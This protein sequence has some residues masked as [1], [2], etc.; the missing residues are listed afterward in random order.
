MCTRIAEINARKL[1]IRTALLAD[2]Q[3][4]NFDAI[5]TELANLEKEE[6][7]L[8]SKQEIANQI[9]V[10]KIEAT[11][12]KKPEERKM[13]INK[14]ETLE[15]RQAFMAHVLKGEAIPA[16]FRANQIT[17]TTDIGAV[18]PTNVLNKV[19][20]KVEATGMIL[21]LVTR[22]AFK[23]GL[24]IPKSGVKPVATWVAE[25]ATSDKQK[26]GTA[27][28]VFAYHKLRC[29]VAMSLEADTMA[30][31]AFEAAL[32]QNVSEAMVKAIEQA[33]ISG[34]GNGKPEGILNATPVELIDVTSI[35]YKTLVAAEAAIPS[36]YEA[37]A[38]WIMTKKTFMDF[39]GMVDSSKQP[40]ARINYGISGKPERTLLGRQVVLCNYIDSFATATAGKPV[41]FLFDFSN[42]VLNTNFELGMKRYEDIETEDQVTKA[43]MIVDGKVVDSNSLVV[44]KKKAS[45]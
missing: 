28:I 41:A 13:E 5:K 38:V 18:I 29:A 23:G 11:E 16:E 7:E 17:K 40:I 2:D 36:E 33:I 35:D 20:E 30:L 42:Y 32:I 43:V 1:E 25:G 14:L 19:I 21:S 22:T 34:D 10:G 15:Y 31:P 4:L 6:K 37:N 39:I 9:N 45:A 8:R 24:S 26:K 3:K 12:I 27:N 44:L